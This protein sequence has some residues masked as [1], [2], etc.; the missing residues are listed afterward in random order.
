MDLVTVQ[1]T[2]EPIAVSDAKMHLRVDIADDDIYIASLI[3]A[4]RQS[5]EDFCARAFITQTRQTTVD[6]F[7]SCDSDPY[8]RSAILRLGRSPVISLTSITYV[9]TAGVTQTLDPTKYQTDLATEPARIL[10]AYGLYWPVVRPQL[11]AVTA[12]YVAGYGLAPAV[13]DAIK[14]AMRIL[15]SHWYENRE[16]VIIGSRMDVL[17]MTVEHLLGPYRIYTF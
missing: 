8:G 7:Y 14:H 16:P 5:C 12:T 10:P 1:P 9:D 4:A 2:T 11:S 6:S 15:I 13:P 17:P 3:K